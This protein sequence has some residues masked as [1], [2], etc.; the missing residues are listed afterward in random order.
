MVKATLLAHREL[1]ARDTHHAE[2]GPRFYCGKMV[3]QVFGKRYLVKACVKMRIGPN[4]LTLFWGL[5]MIA[6]GAWVALYGFQNGWLIILLVGSGIMVDGLDGMVA[7]TRHLVSDFGSLLDAIMHIVGDAFLITGATV[8]LARGSPAPYLYW[9]AVSIVVALG[10]AKLTY[11][12]ELINANNED[13]TLR[14][15]WTDKA[16]RPRWSLKLRSVFKLFQPFTPVAVLFGVATGPMGF[17]VMITVLACSD[18]LVRI[19][20]FA[21]VDMRARE[22]QNRNA[23]IR[24]VPTRVRKIQEGMEARRYRARSA[25]QR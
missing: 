15:A 24:P 14:S 16:L 6:A 7:R 23:I 19:I 4:V 18:L 9:G 8:D 2:R 10:G 17:A 12:C 22:V 13:A 21:I 25:K 3:R 20:V 1:P 5:C 11:F